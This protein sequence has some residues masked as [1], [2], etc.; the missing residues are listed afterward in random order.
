[1]GSQ[2]AD[3]TV[4][5]FHAVKIV[6]TAEGGLVATQEASLARKLRLLRSHGSTRD[7]ITMGASA[8][9]PWVY[10]QVEL[11]FN[12]RLTDLQAVLGRSQLGRLDA[13]QA[14]RG[15]RADGYDLLLTGLP[16]RLPPRLPDRTS[17]WH[18]YAV[19]IDPN[20]TSATRAEVFAALRDAD[21]GV[22]VHY[23]PIHTQPYY[24]RL[25][26]RP[27]AFPAAEGYY[28]NALSLPLFPALTKQQQERVVQALTAALA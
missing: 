13:M 27:G 7:A 17:A 6:T 22:N 1:V 16:L 14:M 12:Y 23:I 8:D 21:I 9:G 11:G 19:E 2:W 4:F 26:F 18:L 3:L 28:S 25:G 24:R 10:H 15:E 5:S 20:R